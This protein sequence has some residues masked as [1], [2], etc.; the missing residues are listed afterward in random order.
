VPISGGLSGPRIG[1]AGCESRAAPSWVQD[2]AG[3]LK[4]V[5]F[6]TGKPQLRPPRCYTRVTPEEKR[7]FLARR[8]QETEKQT[9][10]GLKTAPNLFREQFSLLRGGASKL[11]R[12]YTRPIHDFDL[13]ATHAHTP[14]PAALPSVS[15]G[16]VLVR[17]RVLC[18]SSSQTHQ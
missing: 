5:P 12:L 15:F 4:L 16:F 17:V 9:Q 13:R 6:N 10:K 2:R 8:A 1:T 3:W 11:P 18:P 7:R 14:L